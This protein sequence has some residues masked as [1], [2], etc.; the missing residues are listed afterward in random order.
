MAGHTSRAYFFNNMYLSSIQQGIQAGHV[1]AEM[2]IKYVK[3]SPKDTIYE[4][5]AKDDKVMIVLNGGYVSN[6]YYIQE[7]I[8]NLDFPWAAFNESEEAMDG[9]LTSVGVI[10]PE[11]IYKL[12]KL[13]RDENECTPTE[14]EVEEYAKFPALWPIAVQIDAEFDEELKSVKTLKYEAQSIDP[15][16]AYFIGFLNNCQLAR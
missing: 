11:W 6:L 13:M 10:L 15:K 9:M 5:W 12:A 1:I 4:K 14:E 7:A 8:A 2:S 3:E 16:L